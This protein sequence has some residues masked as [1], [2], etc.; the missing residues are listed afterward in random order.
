[1]RLSLP[2]SS[3]ALAV[4]LLA[5][6]SRSPAIEIGDPAPPLQ[7]SQWVRGEAVELKA[8]VDRVYVVEF[9][10]T[11]CRPCTAVIPMLS[12]LQRK[13]EAQG[14][15]VVA[16]SSEK[17]AEVN[18]PEFV[19][20]REARI[21]YRVAIDDKG[22]TKRAYLDAFGSP[23]IIPQ[24]F[25]INQ[26]G[27]IV[28]RGHP[29]E[30]ESVLEDVFAG[31]H[32][33]KAARERDAAERRERETAEVNERYK[34][35][36]CAPASQPGSKETG[37]KL[38]DLIWDNPERLNRFAYSI[39]TSP[40]I[41]DRHYDLAV[42][43]AERAMVLTNEKD[44]EIIDTYAIA[45]Y[46]AGRIDEAISRQQ[47]AIRICRVEHRRNQMQMLLAQYQDSKK[48]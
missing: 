18:V 25:V 9:W 1:M 37:Q 34:T 2:A 38:L 30:L 42:K 24:S 5:A 20:R 47:H 17:D 46:K 16:V 32:D 22:Q 11:W 28:W 13:Y 27:L 36:I 43:A 40:K 10:A 4:L 7:I 45:L 33:I 21:A 3:I 31:R 41:N 29:A 19:Q 6:V 39:A 8:D 35:M 14:L 26:A 23:E 44:F 48:R 15:V 12:R